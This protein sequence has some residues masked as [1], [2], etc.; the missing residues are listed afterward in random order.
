MVL[1]SKRPEL[2]GVT[3]QLERTCAV[4][5]S[6]GIIGSNVMIGGSV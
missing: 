6:I 4:I 2:Y 3:G 5:P 1:L